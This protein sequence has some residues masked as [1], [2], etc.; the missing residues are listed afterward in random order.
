MRGGESRPIILALDSAGLACS[1]AVAAGDRVL[2]TEHIENLHGQAEALLPMV[3]ATMRRAGLGPAALD[4]VAVTLG[5]GSFTGIRVGLAGA[6]GIVI[7]TGARLIGVTSFDAVVAAIQAIGG[8]GSNL[9]VALES[10]RDDLYVQFFD[11]RFDAI[12]G[13]TAILPIAL[14]KAV[15]ATIGAAPLAIAGDAAPRAFLALAG[16]PHIG[17]LSD[18]NPS[19]VGVLRA[20]LHSLRLGAAADEPRP[21]YLRPPSV[22]LSSGHQEPGRDPA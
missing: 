13:P 7:A 15:N 6:R 2:E 19:A 4:L 18:P 9:L 14:G 1:V 16:R 3:D 17:V 8:R 11:P 21:L 10:R 12:G 22:T 20:G 5:P